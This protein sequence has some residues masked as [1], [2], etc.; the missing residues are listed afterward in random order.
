MTTQPEDRNRAWGPDTRF[1]PPRS[2]V[3][4]TAT[5]L[6]ALPEPERGA[7]GILRSGAIMAV[8]TLASRVT[9]FLRTAMLVA[10]LGTGALGDAYNTAN[11]VPFIVYDLLL[12]GVLTAVVVP[13]IVRARERDPA[14]GARYEQRLFTLAVLGLALITAV[15]VALGPVFMS[16]YGGSMHGDQRE[17]AV[18]FARLFAVQIFFLGVSAFSGAIL[19]TRKRFGAPMWAPVLNNIVI[20]CTAGA[21]L[22]VA[23]G[24]VDPSTIGTGEVGLLA[25][26]TIGG[27]ALQTLALWPS[28]RGS[29]FRWRPRLDF[30][31]GELGEMGRM[32]VWTL[33]YVVITQIGFAITTRLANSAGVAGRAKHLGDVGYTPYFNAYQLFQLPY[34]IIGVSVITALLPRMSEHAAAGRFGDVRDDFSTGMRLCAVIIFPA[35]GLM[36]VLGPEIATVLFAH[37]QTSVANAEVIA[38]VLRMFAVALVPFAAYQLTLRVFYALQDT[39]TPALIAV[40]VVAVNIACALAA[41]RLLPTDKIIVGIAGGFAL[42]QTTGALLGWAVLRRRLGGMDGRRIIATD[43]RLIVALWP[44]LG[45]AYAVHAVLRAGLGTGL[46]PGL[47]ALAAGSAGGGLLYLLFARLMR[48]GEVQTMIGTVTARLPGRR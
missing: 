29:G 20:C 7:G 12:G 24:G 35:A 17:L 28:L 11:T 37:G 14:H 39:R 33:A 15:A 23:S 31:R 44:L 2:P 6:P 13:L 19:N 1:P 32:A 45:L 26:G 22:L 42:A 4:E 34:A 9:G 8:G 27:M 30:R 16:I 38:E 5:D 3:E 48:V 41:S 25:A 10:A 21:F 18:L 40:A 47:L 46:V 43:L 36:G